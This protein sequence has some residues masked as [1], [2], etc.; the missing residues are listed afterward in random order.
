MQ[1]EA[2]VGYNGASDGFSEDLSLFGSY[3]GFKYRVS[4]SNTN[5]GNVRT[6]DGTLGNTGFKQKDGSAFLSYDFS[7]TFTVGG[8]YDYFD[9]EFNA[10]SMD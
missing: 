10:T 6:P 3:E 1:G 2:S 5:Q 7:D 8:S 4:G 9:G